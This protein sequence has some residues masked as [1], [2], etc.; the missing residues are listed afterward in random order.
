M[1]N[2]IRT[3]ALF[4]AFS[5]IVLEEHAAASENP[6]A[7]DEA[8]ATAPSPLPM[9]TLVDK[10]LKTNSMGQ[11]LELCKPI[12]DD[13]TDKPSEGALVLGIWAA[14]HMKWANV[15]T[16]RNET[17]FALAMKDSEEARGKRVCVSGGI[18]QIAVE[19]TDFG[20][21]N[22]GLL[23]SDEGDIYKFMN[24][25]TSG[26]LVAN[27]QARMCGVVTGRYQYSNSAGGTGHALSIVGM[28]DLPQNR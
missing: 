28:F 21:F 23:M 17:S 3:V 14:K 12:M 8:S 22:D 18:I 7:S 13:T 10:L 6:T 27:S 9:K 25:G 16:N 24:V 11:A 15:A 5:G 4:L 20:K 26:D 2:S 19:R 1:K